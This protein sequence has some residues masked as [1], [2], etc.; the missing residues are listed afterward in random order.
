MLPEHHTA[1]W[2][3]AIQVEERTL[4]VYVEVAQWN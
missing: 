1:L 3:Q 4:D 2:Q